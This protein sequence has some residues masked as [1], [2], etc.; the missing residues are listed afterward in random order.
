MPDVF[1]TQKHDTENHHC[2]LPGEP[3]NLLAKFIETGIF[4]ELRRKL[5]RWLMISKSHPYTRVYA[6]SISRLKSEVQRH[7]IDH[8]GIIHPLSIFSLYFNFLV[9]FSF[10]VQYITAPISYAVHKDLKHLSYFLLPINIL[11]FFFIIVNFFTGVYSV[12][13][14]VVIMKPKQIAKSYAKS[15]LILDILGYGPLVLRMLKVRGMISKKTVHHLAPIMVLLRYFRYIWCLKVLSIARLYFGFSNFKFYFLKLTLNLVVINVLAIYMLYTCL[16]HSSSNFSVGSFLKHADAT[17]QVIMMVNHGWYIE[18]AGRTFGPL[19]SVLFIIGGFCFHLV[20]LVEVMSIWFR[21]SSAENRQ[22]RVFDSVMAYVSYRGIPTV[23]KK[24]VD[25][26][27]KFKYKGTFYKES[28]VIK[29][30]SNFLREEILL[31]ST[32]NILEKVDLFRNIP[33]DLKLKLRT[34]MTT[35]IF[36]TDDVIFRAK[37]IGTTMYFIISGSVLVTSPFNEEIC[38]LK[39]GCHFGVSALLLKMSRAVNIIAATPC[40]VCKLERNKFLEVLKGKPRLISDMEIELSTK[41]LEASHRTLK[42]DFVY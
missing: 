38:Y 21:Y 18:K 31:A 6:P 2:T 24:K 32:K 23:I 27:L 28:A 3:W 15:Y 30:T 29:S 8:Y 25:I 26:Y 9:C 36:L 41:I 19:L 4:V 12:N 10:I 14:N 13:D 35:E 17:M 40:E 7:L 42:S 16:P 37:S 5:K 39:D 33:F 11:I 22:A 1:H 34:S 20:V